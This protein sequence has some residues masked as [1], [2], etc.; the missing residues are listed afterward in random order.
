MKIASPSRKSPKNFSSEDER[1]ASNKLVINFSLVVRFLAINSYG[2][3]FNRPYH[4]LNHWKDEEKGVSFPSCNQQHKEGTPLMTN[5]ARLSE[6]PL[7]FLSLTAY[8][9]GEFQA[10]LPTF[11]TAFWDICRKTRWMRRNGRSGAL[12]P[13]ATVHCPRWKI[14]YY[15]FWCIYAKLPPGYFWGSVPN[16]STSGQ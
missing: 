10:L 7:P 4:D 1:K 13:I 11:S 2:F 15:S 9:V 12:S 8:T 6:K 14:S 3:L 5:Y 16:A